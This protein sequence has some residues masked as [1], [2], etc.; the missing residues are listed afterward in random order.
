M[1]WLEALLA[2]AALLA[3]AY[4]LLRS[5]QQGMAV[6]ELADELRR[7]AARWT[8]QRALA[9]LQQRVIERQKLAENVVD[10]GTAA[11]RAVHLGISRIPFGILEAIP[12]TRAPARAVRQTH[13]L[14]SNAVYG[15]IRGLNK[16]VGQVTR[17][18]L[19]AAKS[20]RPR[21]SDSDDPSDPV[22]TDRHEN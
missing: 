20:P 17:G 22:L 7:D 5:R 18:A 16:A 12:A 19:D 4:V 3:T 10:S 6:A 9:D 1:A 11:V 2:L 8:E 21:R 15:S 13:D 14:I